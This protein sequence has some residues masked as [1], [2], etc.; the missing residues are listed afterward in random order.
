MLARKVRMQR[1][2][3]CLPYVL[4]VF[5]CACLVVC[6]RSVRHSGLKMR[7]VCST[8]LARKVRMQRVRHCLPYVLFVCAVC[9][10]GAYK[11]EV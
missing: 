3:H 1:V 8:M 4:F 6:S 5:V 9:A 10:V 11:C 2:R 7:G